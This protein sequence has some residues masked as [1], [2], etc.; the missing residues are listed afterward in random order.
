MTEQS[1]PVF[2]R[3]FRL[4]YDEVRQAWIVLAP[5]RLFMLDEPAAEVLK[6]VDGKRSVAVIVDALAARFT[7]PRAEIASDVDAMLRDLA[8]KGAIQL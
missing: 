7:A 5:E 1:V 8:E 2:R 3:G 6:L 4:R